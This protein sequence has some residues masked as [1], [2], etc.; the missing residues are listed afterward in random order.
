MPSSH[1]QP[2]VRPL[3]S[4][5]GSCRVSPWL[6]RLANDCPSNPISSVSDS[7]RCVSKPLQELCHQLH[8]VWLKQPALQ[9]NNEVMVL[10]STPDVKHV[11]CLGT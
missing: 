2:C 4:C 5:K 3:H 1:M 9:M 11:C 6:D 8:N 7:S 10:A